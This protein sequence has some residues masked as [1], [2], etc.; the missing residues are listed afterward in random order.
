MY[1]VERARPIPLLF[2][3]EGDDDERSSKADEAEAFAMKLAGPVAS[4][5]TPGL[6]PG[7][8]A[9]L[10]LFKLPINLNEETR[11]SGEKRDSRQATRDSA[12]PKREQ[13]FSRRT[14]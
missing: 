8:F 5:I 13:P 12:S 14:A 2:E 9:A 7:R 4:G 1:W 11:K 3:P 6:K 10:S